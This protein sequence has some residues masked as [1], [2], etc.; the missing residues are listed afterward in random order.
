MS[1]IQAHVGFR[2]LHYTSW[3]KTSLREN[4]M[5]SFILL[6]Y[7]QMGKQARLDILVFSSTNCCDLQLLSIQTTTSA[8]ELQRYHRSLA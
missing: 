2:V 5:L 3:G 8:E 7:S 4:Q 1:V 6:D